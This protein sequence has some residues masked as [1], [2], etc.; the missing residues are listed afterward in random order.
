[1]EAQ[2]VYGYLGIFGV[3]GIEAFESTPRPPKAVFPGRMEIRQTRRCCR[4]WQAPGP[5][6]ETQHSAIWRASEA[7]LQAGRDDC[8]DD[9]DDDADDDEDDEGDADNDD[10]D[11]DDDDEDNETTATVAYKRRWRDA[12]LQAA[13]GGDLTWG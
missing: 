9:E 12:V 4:R 2:V 5:R 1:M 11:D 10:D 13:G 3:V 8:D 7:A 6:R